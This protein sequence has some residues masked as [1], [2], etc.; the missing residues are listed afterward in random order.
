MTNTTAVSQF[1]ESTFMKCSYA[2]LGTL[3]LVFGRLVD[4]ILIPGDDVPQYAQD[5]VALLA[6]IALR[7]PSTRLRSMEL[8]IATDEATLMNFL[9]A[10][11]DTLRSV[12]PTLLAEIAQDLSLQNLAQLC[13]FVPLPGSEKTRRRMLFAVDDAVWH[14]N[15]GRYQADYRA[16]VNHILLRKASHS[17]RHTGNWAAKSRVAILSYRMKRRLDNDTVPSDASSP[18]HKH[19]RTDQTDVYSL[20]RLVS[21]PG[22]IVPSSISLELR[23]SRT[24]WGRLDDNTVTHK[25]RQNALVPRRAFVAF[26][27]RST[28]DAQIDS[29]G[30]C[31][32]ATSGILIN[33][34]HLKSKNKKGCTLYGFLHTGDK[35]KVYCGPECVEFLCEI[36][37]GPGEKPRPAGTRFKVL[38]DRRSYNDDTKT[39]RSQTMGHSSSHARLSSTR[40]YISSIQTSDRATNSHAPASS[41][42]RTSC[43][44]MTFS[45]ENIH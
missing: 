16:A 37:V 32:F 42:R 25:D 14:G 15:K 29:I 17:D 2:L 41:R 24:S 13:D 45:D 39:A 27:H 31:T 10:H 1:P 20:G 5:P 11:K 43:R 22:P 9:L 19:P 18:S 30:I 23:T 33:G 7:T 38:V 4:G 40:R 8:E 36:Y 44:H 12:T 34:Q 3:N 6:R 26:H 28:D 21:V 35:V